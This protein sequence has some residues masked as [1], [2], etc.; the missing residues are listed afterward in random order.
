MLYLKLTCFQSLVCRCVPQRDYLELIYQS[1]IY[2]F[3]VSLDAVKCLYANEKCVK[4][5]T[6]NFHLLK[7]YLILMQMN[8][9][10]KH[11]HF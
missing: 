7:K 9:G 4:D 10:Y 3:I 11:T 6:S 2:Q 5:S 1:C 8:I